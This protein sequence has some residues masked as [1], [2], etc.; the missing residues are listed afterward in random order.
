MI[1]IFGESNMIYLMDMGT[2]F[3][4][5]YKNQRVSIE[6]GEY[7]LSLANIDYDGLQQI[8]QSYLDTFTSQFELATTL[9]QLNPMYTNIIQKY[10]QYGIYPNAV[11]TEVL[12]KINSTL[13]KPLIQFLDNGYLNT[14]QLGIVARLIITELENSIQT[15]TFNW[16][17]ETTYVPSILI[18]KEL[19]DQLENILL[20]DSTYFSKEIRKSL[21]KKIISSTINVD[22]NG[23]ARTTFLIK[24]TLAFMMVD[25]QK[26]LAEENTVLRCQNPNCNR[27]FYP[28][29]SKNKTYCRLKHNDTNLLCN[30]IIHRQSSDEF[31]EYAKKARGKQRGFVENAKTH[32]GNP[33]YEYNYE[34]LENT[35]T[36]WKEQCTNEMENY[37][38]SNDIHGFEKWISDTMFTVDRLEKLGIRTVKKSDTNKKG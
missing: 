25:L 6:Y 9:G 20:R 16:M 36:L 11:K 15:D 28:K 5:I 10:E 17:D 3:E 13:Y 14:K 26:Y 8:I 23:I 30:E 4:M 21:S 2:H 37:R 32:E 29:S 34:L 31:A 1:Y 33:K 12:K 24:D 22:K 35:Y 27:L 7:T 18:Y 19:K 38:T